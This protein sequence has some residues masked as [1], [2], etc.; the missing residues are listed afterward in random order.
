MTH[1]SL[2]YGKS[3]LPST[4]GFDRLLSTFEEFDNLLG[5][6][7]KIQTYPPYN[8]IKEDNETY[9]IEIAVSGFKRDEIEIT[10]EGGKLYVNG[11]SKTARTSDKYLHRGIG[12]RD[13]SHKFVLSDTVVVRDADIVDGLLVINLEN[14]IPEEKKPRKIEIGSRKT[15]DLLP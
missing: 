1:L 11:A 15:T 4:V 3:L 9:T 8:I 10:S 12:T 5:Q 6:G 7:T 2:P 14:I 13:F